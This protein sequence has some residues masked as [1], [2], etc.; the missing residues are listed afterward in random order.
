V[1]IG[2]SHS[3][4]WHTKELDFIRIRSCAPQTAGLK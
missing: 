1:T 3:I 4:D 2:A